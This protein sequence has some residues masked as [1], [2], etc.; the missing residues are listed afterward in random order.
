MQ[1]PSSNSSPN[2]LPPAAQQVT[3]LISAAQAGEAAA[4]EE[5]L[6]LVY[7][8]L[9]R[10]AS[11]HL[12]KE[13]SGITLQPTA[14]VH[15]AYVR[16][17]GATD[18]EWNGKGHFF[19]AAAQAMRRILIDSARARAALKRGGAG[20]RAPAEALETLACSDPSDGPDDSK[21]D[22]LALNGALERLESKDRRQAEVVMLRYFA[23]LTIEQTAQA[24][25]L[26]TGT[27]KNE[28]TFARA[29]LR[30]EMTALDPD[31]AS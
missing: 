30:R 29:W 2:T 31:L 4:A 23:G 16:L 8:E 18:I 9:R 5:L 19:A 11:S 27:V 20:H 7:D 13:P 3:R 22:L 6:P 1:G 26:S 14:L 10:L 15:E 21:V 25:G 17:L 28:W 24:M 12:A